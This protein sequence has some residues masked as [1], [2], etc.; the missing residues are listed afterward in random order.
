[1]VVIMKLIINTIDG[2]RLTVTLLQ[3]KMKMVM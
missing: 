1:M 3:L 2:E